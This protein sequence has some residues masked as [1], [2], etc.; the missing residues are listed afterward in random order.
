MDIAAGPAYGW[1]ALAHEPKHTVHNGDWLTV[2]NLTPGTYFFSRMKRLDVGDVHIGVTVDR[3]R[4]TLESGQSKSIA[5]VRTQGYPIRGEVVGITNGEA[6]G[7]LVFVRTA[8]S[9]AD[10]QA[11]SEMLRENLD[12][13]T[14]GK[15]GQFQTAS[16]EPGTYTTS[17]LRFIVRKPMSRVTA[18]AFGCRITSAPPR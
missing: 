12:A 5:L 17:R 4:F 10:R 9:G 15:D 1:D 11:P 18:R 7:A 13:L 16:L 14:C 2:T 3:M 6:A 8:E